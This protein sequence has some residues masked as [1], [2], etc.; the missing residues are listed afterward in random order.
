LTR[1]KYTQGKLSAAQI[2]RLNNIGM[3]WRGNYDS[4]WQKCYEYAAE[5]YAQH[6]HL[7]I[8]VAY[9]TPDGVALGVWVRRQRLV[10]KQKERRERLEAIGMIWRV[11][12]G[13]VKSA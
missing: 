1:D 3:E 11:D 6:G 2:D 8:P 4:N 7:N 9:K 13:D 10:E 12:G 5:Y